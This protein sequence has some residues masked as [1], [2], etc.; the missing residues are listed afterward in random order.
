MKTGL[1]SVFEAKNAPKVEGEEE[2]PS[3]SW[4]NVNEQYEKFS[5]FMD[6]QFEFNSGFFSI[7]ALYV[8]TFA[9]FKLKTNLLPSITDSS[10]AIINEIS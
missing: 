3:N 7:I 6:Q 2:N 9:V 4:D 8:Q 5:G 1:V 10:M